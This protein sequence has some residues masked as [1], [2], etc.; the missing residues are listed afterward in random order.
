MNIQNTKQILTKISVFTVLALGIVNP[1]RAA[2]I[3]DVQFPPITK[4]AEIGGLI[5]LYGLPGGLT[6]ED[7]EDNVLTSALTLSQPGAS[8][9]S[10]ASGSSSWNTSSP[11]YLSW[12][13]NTSDYLNFNLDG[14]ATLFAIGI[15]DVAIEPG[16][17]VTVNGTDSFVYGADVDF[18][19]GGGQML[20]GFLIITT[21]SGSIINDVK[22]SGGANEGI[23]FDS[24]LFA[25]APVP[26]PAAVWLFGSG[27]LGL[28][29]V[30]RR[31]AKINEVRI[32]LN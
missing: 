3:F 21:D 29:G 9:I 17:T 28:V 30:A 15:S 7:F 8:S 19:Q 22:F 27:L 11:G 13:Q 23:D 2:F 25:P 24:L 20:N 12:F 6:G 31:K 32:G 14:G 18:Q 5:S 26:V 1:S 10:F 4:P 16:R